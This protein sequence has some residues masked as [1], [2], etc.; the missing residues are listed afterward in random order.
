MTLQVQVSGT[1][2]DGARDYQEDAFLITNLTDNNG[3]TSSLVIVADG[4][5]GHAAGNVASNMAVQ[6][7]NKHFGENYPTDDVSEV[8]HDSILK[9]NASLTDTIKETAALDGMGCTM[10][11][12][13]IEENKLWWASVGDSHLYLLRDKKLIKL[14]ENHSYGGFLDRMEA[15]GTPVEP[16]KALSRNMLMSA[17]TGDD[18][19]EVDCPLVPFILESEDRLIVCSDGLDT[20]SEGK[21][22]QYTTWSDTP[23]E[24]AADLLNAVTEL[25]VPKQDN[26]TVVVLLVNDQVAVKP[27]ESFEEVDQDDVTLRKK[28]GAAVPKVALEPSPPIHLEVTQDTSDKSGLLTNITKIILVMLI[29]GGGYFVYSNFEL[30]KTIMQL[31]DTQ[32]TSTQTSTDETLALLEKMPGETVGKKTE[33]PSKPDQSPDDIKTSVSVST[34]AEKAQQAAVKKPVEAATNKKIFQDKLKVGGLGPIMVSIPAGSFL[35]GSTSISRFIEERPRHKV[36]ISKFAVSQHEITFIQYGAFIKATNRKA[37]KGYVANDAKHPVANITWDDAHN[38]ARWLSEQTGQKYRLLS[39]SEWEYMARGSS[40]TTFWWG[41][42]PGEGNAHCFDCESGY[43]PRKPTK[44]GSF[45]PN[46]FEVYDTAG[47]VAEW[48][49][50]CWHRNYHNAPTTNEPWEGGDC[51]FRVVRGGGYSNPSQSIRS[52]KRDK[53][54]A[55]RPYDHVGIRVAREIK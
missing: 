16:E 22:I 23:K 21:I 27:V 46:K 18:I 30:K 32:T 6:A 33:T 26:T 12:A 36:N 49:K 35:Q 4:M 38:Y 53:L 42:E 8:L 29:V 31:Y 2:I 19:A 54:T 14:N 52:A 51:R 44:I 28:V 40:T 5:G 45:K 3:E 20:L 17:L 48:V 9:A 7:F 15:A 50:D 39:E 43:D 37:P 13:I 11:S 24:C 47:N 10:V 25:N 34:Q 41:F 55:N 1:Q